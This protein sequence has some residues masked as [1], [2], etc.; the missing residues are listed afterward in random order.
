[1]VKSVQKQIRVPIGD[2]G[3]I[4]GNINAL[5]L[6]NSKR[7]MGTNESDQRLLRRSAN[8]TKS[9]IFVDF[10][11]HLHKLRRIIIENLRS[12]L[13]SLQQ[14]AAS[15][16]LIASAH[17]LARIVVRQIRGSRNESVDA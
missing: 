13:K 10:D 2:D 9:H 12:A 17:V 1:M 8:S 14:C 15:A 6:P 4:D 5:A 7:A 3:T 11:R 16:R